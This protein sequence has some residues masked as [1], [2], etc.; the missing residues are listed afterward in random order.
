MTGAL[1]ILQGLIFTLDERIQ[2]ELPKFISYLTCGLRRE[3]CDAMGTR[4]AAGI[5]SDLSNSIGA[6]MS[7]WLPDIMPLLQ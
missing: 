2:S 5:I 3:N 1:F 4:N 7:Q 6:G